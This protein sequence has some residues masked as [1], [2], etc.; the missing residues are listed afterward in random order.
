MRLYWVFNL[1][2]NIF[3]FQEMDVSEIENNKVDPM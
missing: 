1:D 3:D 2:L